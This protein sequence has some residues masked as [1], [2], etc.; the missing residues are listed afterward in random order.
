MLRAAGG[1]FKFCPGLV[2]KNPKLQTASQP[3]HF[4]KETRMSS[5][6]TN[7]PTST[8]CAH[9]NCNCPVESGQQYCSTQCADSAKQQG[10]STQSAGQGDCG[11]HHQ[12][13]AIAA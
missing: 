2:A 8:K 3:S 4:S 12:N 11:C 9:Q 7:T 13:C 1:T 6:I 5:V 10:S